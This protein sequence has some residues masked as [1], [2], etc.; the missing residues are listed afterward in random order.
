MKEAW[1]LKLKRFEDG[2]AEILDFTELMHNANEKTITTGAKAERS[3]NKAGLIGQGVLGALRVCDVK[4]GVE[5]ELGSG[6]T[7]A[8]RKAL[9]EKGGELRGLLVTYQFFPLG[10]KDKPR[11]PTFKGFRSP[12]DF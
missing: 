5:F 6:F 7:A 10:S 11:F 12:I 1:L 9:W 4:S 3:H 2:E 8:E